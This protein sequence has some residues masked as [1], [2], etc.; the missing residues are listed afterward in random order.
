MSP[1]VSEGN[2]QTDIGTNKHTES[3]REI[4]SSHFLVLII[5]FSLCRFVC[6]VHVYTC[7]IQCIW[8]ACACVDACACVFVHVLWKSEVIIRCLSEFPTALVRVSISVRRKYDQ[9]NCYKG[10]YLWLS[11]CTRDSFPFHKG[12]KHGKI[13]GA[14]RAESSISGSEGKEGKIVWGSYKDILKALH[15]ND[16]LPPIRSCLLTMSLPTG[17]A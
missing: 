14:G 16:I 3:H 6:Y 5:A 12:R 13:H 10:Q 15:H 1:G 7:V 2:R 17:Q 8:G 4:P 11:C 9:S